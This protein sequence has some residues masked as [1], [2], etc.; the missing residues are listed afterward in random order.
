VND[1]VYADGTIFSFDNIDSSV[2]ALEESVLAFL[3]NE[4]EGE[5]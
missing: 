4:K 3:L 1:T 2:T 5:G